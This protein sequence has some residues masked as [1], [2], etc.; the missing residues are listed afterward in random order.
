EEAHFPEGMTLATVSVASSPIANLS[1]PSV[2]F[3]RAAFSGQERITV[4]AGLS[5]KGDTTLRD[6][7]VTLEVDG[8]EIESQRATVQ[9]QT[10]GSVPC[11]PFTLPGPNVRGT[12]RAGPDAMPAD[13]AFHF[14]LTP[15]EPVSLVIVDNSG[16][17]SDASL[18]MTKAL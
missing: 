1:V 9:A 4:T 5:N 10:S 14:V 18:F 6:V 2:T 15:S 11:A 17:E 3:K 8:H 7:P 13:N 16:S 12:V